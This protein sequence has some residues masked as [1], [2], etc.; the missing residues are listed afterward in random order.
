M[1]SNITS[2]YLSEL[3]RG[4]RSP[5]SDLLVRLSHFLGVAPASFLDEE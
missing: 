5:T 1:K 3:E 2:G 4:I